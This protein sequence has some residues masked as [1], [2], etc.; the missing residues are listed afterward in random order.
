VQRKSQVWYLKQ[1][2]ELVEHFLSDSS[3]QAQIFGEKGKE[4][5]LGDALTLLRISQKASQVFASLERR[6]GGHVAASLKERFLNS[7]EFQAPEAEELERIRESLKPYGLKGFRLRLPQFERENLDIVSLSQHALEFGK[8]GL[9][10]QRYKGLGE[11]NPDQLWETTMDPTK[12]AL[13][14]VTVD[15]AVEADS[16]FSVLMGDQVEPRRQFIEDHALSFRN[17]DI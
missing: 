5:Q 1:D 15:D 4:Y 13:L 14:Q 2:A 7:K 11:M 3:K 16:V 9:M 17:L 6:L 8:Q 10:I 12:R